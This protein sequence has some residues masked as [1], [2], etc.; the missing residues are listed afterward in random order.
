MHAIIGNYHFFE[1]ASSEDAD[2]YYWKAFNVYDTIFLLQAP[3]LVLT[4]AR[5]LIVGVL[6]HIALTYYQQFSTTAKAQ[7]CFQRIVTYSIEHCPFDSFTLSHRYL[8]EINYSHYEQYEQA[9]EHFQV[10]ATFYESHSSDDYWELALCNKWLAMVHFKL[11]LYQLSID[12]GL[13]AIDLLQKPRS[14]QSTNKF[15][16]NEF[17]FLKRVTCVQQKNQ[18]A[19]NEHNNEQALSEMYRLIGDAYEQIHDLDLSLAA[20]EY[21]LE[22]NQDFSPIYQLETVITESR[23]GILFNNVKEMEEAS[24]YQKKSIESP[25]TSLY[26]R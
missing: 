25:E 23:L 10:S 7:E 15:V 21:A 19:Y 6:F 5:L 8:G 18:I 2:R 14:S 3:P 26:D 22:I 4:Q 9:V 1:N 16:G 20:Y 11:R 13:K 24:T 17:A 12:Y